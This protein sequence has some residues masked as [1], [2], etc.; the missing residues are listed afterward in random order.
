MDSMLKDVIKRSAIPNILRIRSF[1]CIIIGNFGFSTLTIH[2]C[3]LIQYNI[4]DVRIHS[5]SVTSIIIFKS[6]CCYKDL[7]STQNACEIVN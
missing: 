7:S 3:L 4:L 1:I 6:V 2:E 5:P